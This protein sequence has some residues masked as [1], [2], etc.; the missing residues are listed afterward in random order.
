MIDGEL[1]SN[2]HWLTVHPSYVNSRQS[3]LS[4]FISGRLLIKD[5][6]T[7][8]FPDIPQRPKDLERCLIEFLVLETVSASIIN[9]WKQSRT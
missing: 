3:F 1:S 7:F 8:L 2:D 6:L 9:S 4:L 5:Y